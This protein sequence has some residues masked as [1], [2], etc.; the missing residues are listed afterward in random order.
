MSGTC[1]ARPGH[2]VPTA[3]AIRARARPE[4]ETRAVPCTAP[5][6]R[7]VPNT[8]PTRAE[9][10]VPNGPP[11]LFATPIHQIAELGTSNDSNEYLR[12]GVQ[13][14]FQKKYEYSTAKSHHNVCN[15]L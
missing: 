15:I 10:S 4:P 7:A 2:A 11:D 12:I 6:K 1:Q 8:C 14:D 3:R 5:L 9:P 13:A